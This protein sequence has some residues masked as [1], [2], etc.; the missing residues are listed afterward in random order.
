M[1]GKTEFDN[2]IEIVDHDF[3][4]LLVIDIV[5]TINIFINKWLIV[6]QN[7]YDDLH[8]AVI[9]EGILDHRLFH[10]HRLYNQY[11]LLDY[12]IDE[13]NKTTLTK[14]VKHNYF[15]SAC[16]SYEDIKSL[17][18]I[19]LNKMGFMIK[20]NHIAPVLANNQ[21]IGELLSGM[22][23]SVVRQEIDVNE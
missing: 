5:K 12:V 1:V 16:L 20:K 3:Q 10:R 22:D 14:N 23:F 6:D 18:D 7:Q 8:R 17:I 15:F 21:I 19:Y 4:H 2:F 13:E 9:L 11:Q